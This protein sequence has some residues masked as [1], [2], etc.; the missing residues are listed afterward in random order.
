MAGK[1]VQTKPIVQCLP[2]SLAQ[3]RLCFQRF[4]GLSWGEWVRGRWKPGGDPNEYSGGCVGVRGRGDL[5]EG[6]KIWGR[7][8]QAE[9]AR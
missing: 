9:W 5:T 2:R 7:L 8:G 3:T 1:R 4:S 6:T